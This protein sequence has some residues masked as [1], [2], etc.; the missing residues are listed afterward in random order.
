MTW[1]RHY[2]APGSHE[3][4]TTPSDTVVCPDCG[5]AGGRELAGYQDDCGVWISTAGE[6]CETCGGGGE[7]ETG[8]RM[9]DK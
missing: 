1:L 4:T 2:R 3:W 8:R 5:G 7:I 6:T 9:G